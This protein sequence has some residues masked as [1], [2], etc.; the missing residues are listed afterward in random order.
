MQIEFIESFVILRIG[1]GERVKLVSA[2]IDENVC[3]FFSLIVAY[4]ALAIWML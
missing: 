4:I 2:K 1:K 3:Q